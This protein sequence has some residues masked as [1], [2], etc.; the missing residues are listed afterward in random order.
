[1]HFEVPQDH[2][3]DREETSDGR[4]EVEEEG[5][6]SLE[7]SLMEVV[8]AQKRIL[9]QWCF[10]EH[11]E[12]HVLLQVWGHGACLFYYYLSTHIALNL[13]FFPCVGSK[14]FTFTFTRLAMLPG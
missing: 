4:V 1:V 11:Y 9:D 7:D 2:K 13:A 6:K 14:R 5:E 8:N 3:G 12:P 10:A